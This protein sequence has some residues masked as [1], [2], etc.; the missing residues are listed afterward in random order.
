[1][2]A[3]M[4]KKL[5]ALILI[6]VWVW[7][8]CGCSVIGLG[9]G[10]WS[11]SRK[12]N[13]AIFPGWELEKVKPGQKVILLLRDGNQVKGKFVDLEK[14][15][16]KEYAETYQKL[17]EQKPD[18][19]VLPAIGDTV[20]IIEKFEKKLNCEFF[21]FDFDH[22]TVR[23]MGRNLISQINLNNVKK[24]EQSD[25]SVVDETTLKRLLFEGKIPLRSFIVLENESG[26]TK[27]KIE[28]VKEIQIP[29]KKNGKLRGFLIGAAIDV[30]VIIVVIKLASEDFSFIG[31]FY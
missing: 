31:P 11:D 12:P 20:S 18:G 29:V 15:G 21:G 10:A 26:N 3:N 28:N 30:V 22:I 4:L 7:Q 6:V 13:N 9:I 14:M 24:I 25:G 2:E 19:V 17:V 1:M 27:N 8:F 23:E 5:C 16:E